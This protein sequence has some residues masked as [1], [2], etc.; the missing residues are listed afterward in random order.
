MC[1]LMSKKNLS[2][3][4][5]KR[6]YITPALEA[7]WQLITMETQVTDGQYNLKGN[8]ASRKQANALITCCTYPKTTLLPL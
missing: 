7:K 8:I 2:E 4:D 6:L 1:S 5:I 3:E